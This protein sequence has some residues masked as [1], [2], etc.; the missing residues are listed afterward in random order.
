VWVGGG[1]WGGGG[2]GIALLTFKFALDEGEWS[3][4]RADWNFPEERTQVATEL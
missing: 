4:L 2:G 1:G 3:A